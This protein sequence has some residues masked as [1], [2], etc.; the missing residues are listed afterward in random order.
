MQGKVVGTDL[1]TSFL[2]T[3]NGVIPTG[4]I[5]S[6][7]PFAIATVLGGAGIVTFYMRKKKENEEEEFNKKNKREYFSFYAADMYRVWLD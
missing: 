1:K 5:M 6:V 2:N 7:A 3:R 4:V